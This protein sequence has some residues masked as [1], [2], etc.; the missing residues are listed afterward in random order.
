M[1]T[2][3]LGIGND[4][5]GD[6]GVGLHV[7]RRVARMTR[8]PDITVKETAGTGLELLELI[9]GY[10]RLIVA[11]AVIAA[12]PKPGKIQRRE[13]SDMTN[14]GNDISP[15]EG[16]LTSVIELGKVLFPGEMPGIVS[17]YTI[18]TAGVEEV[19]DKMSTE[20]RQA[21]LR[22]AISILLECNSLINSTP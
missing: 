1:K 15:H 7:A 17:I 8:A 19:T 12:D 22:A 14:A 11:D 13:L 16:S 9:R 10:D 2:L 5:L 21:A 6:D 18:E 4:I 20:V 3:V